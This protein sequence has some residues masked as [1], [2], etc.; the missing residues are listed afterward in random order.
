MSD[1]IVTLARDVAMLIN[2]SKILDA[3]ID[4]ALRIGK[5]N[6][7]AWVRENFSVWRAR[8]DGRV[9]VVHHDGKGGAHWEPDKFTGSLDAAFS[10]VDPDHRW[11]LGVPDGNALYSAK[12]WHS[13]EIVWEAR[14]CHRPQF[15]LCAAAL[16]ARASAPSPSHGDTP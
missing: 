9:E 13:G 14:G 10:L 3:K 12:I 1:D 5:A 4:A 8:P 6:A 11:V 15:A 7:P 2:P 16:Q